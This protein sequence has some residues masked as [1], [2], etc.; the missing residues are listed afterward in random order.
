MKS[1]L[2]TFDRIWK[3]LNETR[4]DLEDIINDARD[5]ATRLAGVTNELDRQLKYLENVG[6][7]MVK[8]S[9]PHYDPNTHPI[10]ITPPPGSPPGAP[11]AKVDLKK[12]NV[13]IGG[14]CFGFH[15]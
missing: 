7:Q 14:T 10:T 11:T 6:A 15:C 3:Q 8:G 12:G 9:V 4:Q 5:Q 2:P 1:S 13:T